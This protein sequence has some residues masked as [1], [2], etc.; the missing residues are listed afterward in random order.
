MTVL[1]YIILH[2]STQIKAQKTKHHKS[3]S[4]GF[5]K[6]RCLT[7]LS[8]NRPTE[9]YRLDW[10]NK[11][12]LLKRFKTRPYLLTPAGRGSLFLSEKVCHHQAPASLTP[13]SGPS[14]TPVSSW[15]T[16][17]PFHLPP[18]SCPLHLDPKTE[19]NDECLIH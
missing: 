8:C 15:R 6:M 10:Q 16:P 4:S 9:H 11:H 2:L 18:E 5:G 3:T 14:L 7:C 19:H 17:P 1:I 13:H 12:N